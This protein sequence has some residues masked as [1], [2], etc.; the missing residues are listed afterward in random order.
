MNKI[1]LI[2]KLD[3]VIRIFLPENEY[4]FD[5]KSLSYRY[6]ITDDIYVVIHFKEIKSLG[7]N[8]TLGY[9]LETYVT[10]FN[11]KIDNEFKKISKRYSQIKK[12]FQPL[13]GSDIGTLMAN[14]T[15]EKKVINNFYYIEVYNEED[16]DK[17]YGQ[18]ELIFNQYIYPFIEKYKSLEEQYFALQFDPL[19]INVLTMYRN[20]GI[21]KSIILAKIMGKTDWPLLFAKYEPIFKEYFN[22]DSQEEFYELRYLMLGH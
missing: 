9:K 15:L 14:P 2:K 19:K 10:L 1:E 11:L 17:N 20:E 5:K 16:F 3:T 22:K 6:N 13:I 18:F 12:E 21:L 4:E 7:P 8:N